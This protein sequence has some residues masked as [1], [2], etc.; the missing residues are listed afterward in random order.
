MRKRGIFICF[1]GVD[2]AGKTTL[3]KL[4]VK[5]M[6]EKNMD[7]KY[8]YSRFIPIFLKPLLI[9]GKVFFLR[10]KDYR[11]NYKE[12]S[13]YKKQISKKHPYISKIYQKLLSLE[14]AIQ[15]ILKIKV[16]LSQGENIICDRYIY[17]TLA[18][19][20][21]IDF[22][23]SENKIKERLENAFTIFPRPDVTFLIDVPE[24][25]AL[26]RKND[27]PSIEY[28]KE[29]R[30]LYLVFESCPEVVKLDGT[31]SIKTLQDIVNR[32]LQK[33]IK[34]EKNFDNW[35]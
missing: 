17:D 27:I 15:I 31:K 26:S 11:K 8:V 14:Y 5:T 12:Y 29:R 23:Y 33:V 4:T 9:F 3:A 10:K 16:P 7:F 25:V 19:D 13:W 18:T 35:H 22:N 2:G 6:K 1:I 32:K 20:L 34:N 28:L 30:K 21:S 24:E